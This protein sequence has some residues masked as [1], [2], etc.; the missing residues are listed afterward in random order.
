MVAVFNELFPSTE[1]FNCIKKCEE[2]KLNLI[3]PLRLVDDTV[4]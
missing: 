4:M 1:D 2:I 3:S